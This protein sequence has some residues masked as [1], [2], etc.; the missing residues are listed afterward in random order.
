M[1][2]ATTAALLAACFASVAQG[3]RIIQGNDDG[4]A[5]L[6]VRSANLALKAKG[7]EV[8]LSAPADNKSGSSESILLSRKVF[9]SSLT[10]KVRETRNQSLARMPASTTLARPTAARSA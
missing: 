3:V 10:I 5:E 7:H 2:A 8:I 6:Y 9:V 1:R 4:W